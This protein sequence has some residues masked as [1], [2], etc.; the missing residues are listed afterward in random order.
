MEGHQS[1]LL[2]DGDLVD[3]LLDRWSSVQ[4]EIALARLDQL[5][6][7]ESE[8][9]RAKLKFKYGLTTPAIS[10]S[11][12]VEYG[13]VEPDLEPRSWMTVEERKV[14]LEGLLVRPRTTYAVI[15]LAVDGNIDLLRVCPPNCNLSPPSGQI[16]DSAIHW[17]CMRSGSADK[18]WSADLEQNIRLIESFLTLS[19]PLVD[20]F[21]SAVERDLAKLPQPMRSKACH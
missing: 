12:I 5:H 9:L 17:R 15:R 4:G 13:E 1:E 18:K 2:S 14:Y 8:V 16:V 11:H 19:Q 10:D 21:N 3:F 6:A 20:A 7:R